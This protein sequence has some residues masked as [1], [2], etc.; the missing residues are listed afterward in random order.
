MWIYRGNKLS[1]STE[2]GKYGIQIYTEDDRYT[3]TLSLR[4]GRISDDD[5]GRYQCYADNKY[6]SDEGFF[7]LY[8]KGNNPVVLVS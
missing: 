5:F 3:K 2:Y 1:E 8:G 4:I 6:G 7:V